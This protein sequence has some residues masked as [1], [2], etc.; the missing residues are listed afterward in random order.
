VYPAGEQ[1]IEGFD[2]VSYADAVR[3]HGHK[4][5]LTVDSPEELPATVA[6]LVQPG[7]AI[8]FLGAGSSTNWANGLEAVLK[9]QAG[10]R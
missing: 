4:S 7:G 2:H 10:R 5:V 8:I 3:A 6:P 1:P 9:A